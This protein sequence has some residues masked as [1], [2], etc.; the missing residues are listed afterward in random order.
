VVADG[1]GVGVGVGPGEDGCE[2]VGEAEA[3]DSDGAGVFG[4]AVGRRVV[5][6]RGVGV[7]PA[8]LELAEGDG[9]AAFGTTSW[10]SIRKSN[11]GILSAHE[12]D[13]EMETLPNACR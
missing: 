11:A 3:P 13:I 7:G 10:M 12:G 8:G 2:G 1:G 4:I 9:L 6:G 5:T